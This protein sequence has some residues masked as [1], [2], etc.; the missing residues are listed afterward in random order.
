MK[1]CVSLPECSLGKSEAAGTWR[2]NSNVGRAG[3]RGRSWTQLVLLPGAES[4]ML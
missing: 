1:V 4:A 2:R 3:A